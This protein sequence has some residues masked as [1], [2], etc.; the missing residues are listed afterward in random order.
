MTKRAKDNVFLERFSW[1]EMWV[2]YGFCEI[3]MGLIK[4]F[5]LVVGQRN[6][7]LIGYQFHFG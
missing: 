7:R 3:I 1:L 6:C 4:F 2:V 5:D